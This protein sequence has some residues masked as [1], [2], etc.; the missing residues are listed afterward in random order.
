MDSEKPY[1]RTVHTANSTTD[2]PDFF[3]DIDCRRTR[4]NID[5]AITCIEKEDFVFFLEPN[6]TLVNPKYLNIH[7]VK[8]LYTATNNQ[9]DSLKYY[10]I[11]LEVGVNYGW[12]R[13]ADVMPRVYKFEVEDDDGYPYVSECSNRGLCNQDVGYC[14]CFDDYHLDDC[15]L[16]QNKITY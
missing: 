14:V 6:A 15:S 12:N 5:G 11:D 8:K 2:F 4:S 9:T 13:T 1:Q 7:T 10:N 3:G 16:L